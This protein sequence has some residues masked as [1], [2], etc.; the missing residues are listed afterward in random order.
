MVNEGDQIWVKVLALDDRGKIRLS[1]KSINQDTGEETE[2]D[3][4]T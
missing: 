4:D 1:I 3:N 2:E